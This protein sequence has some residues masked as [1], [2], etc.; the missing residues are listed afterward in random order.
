MKKELK[1]RA[2]ALMAWFAVAAL[3]VGCQA[4]SPVGQKEKEQEEELTKHYPE[5]KLYTTG[6]SA[7]V[8]GSSFSFILPPGGPGTGEPQP[9]CDVDVA[10]QDLESANRSVEYTFGDRTIVTTP[11][12]STRIVGMD[13]ITNAD[14]DDA[15]PAGSSVADIMELHYIGDDGR[16]YSRM[17]LTDY[18]TTYSELDIKVDPDSAS[19]FVFR[20][21]AKS[22]PL[23]ENYIWRTDLACVDPGHAMLAV[24]FTLVL[25]LADGSVVEITDLIP[26]QKI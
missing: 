26:D 20:L 6:N 8:V 1:N 7:L 5:Y 23:E 4:E 21:S 17:D 16:Y 25:T 22:M 18:F 24:D 14:Y 10:L 12:S 13:V 2:F 19:G 3:G 15:H 9:I 11:L